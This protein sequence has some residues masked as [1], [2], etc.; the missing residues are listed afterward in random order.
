MTAEHITAAD[1]YRFQFVNDVRIAPDGLRVAFVVR[2]V[3][4]ATE[5]KF[6]NLWMVDAAGDGPPRQF[7]Y[8]DHHDGSPTWSP[9]GRWLAFSS[10]RLDAERPAQLFVI[11]TDGGEAHRLVEIPGEIQEIAWSP[12]GARLALVVRKFDPETLERQK[13]EQKKK[14]GVKVRHYERV[15]YKLDGYGY[16]P[17]ERSHIW[18][19]D[20]AAAQA[21]Q[22]TD[23]SVFDETQVAWSPDGLTLAFVSNRM[24][25]PDARPDADKVWL[26][27]AAG[28]EPRQVEGDAWSCHLPAFSP[29]GRRLAFYAQAAENESFRNVQVWLADVDGSTPARSLTA[30]YDLHASSGVIN[31]TNSQDMLPPTW[32][33][34]GRRLLFPV[35]LHG[36]TK[37]VSVSV[38]GD[39]LRTEMDGERSLGAVT[40]DRRQRRAAF[41]QADF[42]DPGQVMAQDWLDGHPNGQARRLT[43]FNRDWLDQIDLGQVETHWIKGPDGNDLQGWII[44]P[45]GFDPAQKY[46][47][48]LEIHGGPLTQYGYAFMHEFYY[49]AAQGYVVT[50]SNPRGGRGYG[51]SHAGAI[52]GAWGTKDYDDLMA[53]TDFVAAQPYIDPERMGVC[54]G[55]YGGYMTVWMLGHTTR[56]KAAVPM[57]CVSNF[58]SMWGTSDFNWAFQY[59]VHAGAPFEDLE[60]HWQRSPIA[61]I[62]AAV[63]PTL[64]IHSEN[65]HRCPIE[66]SEQVFVALKRLGVPTE[67]VR[68]PDEFH[69]LSR[70][71]RTDRR[72]ARLEHVS[73]WF[74]RYLKAE[75][76]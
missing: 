73:R 50:F 19:V 4:Q 24:P 38:D 49:L 39:D 61:Y 17:H 11:P 65:D 37:M 68:F 5:K 21:Q 9:D 63:T 10:N 66:Q 41:M 53:W 1:L 44:K 76:A 20:V 30:A 32:M 25:D 71:G 56:F 28:G 52:D 14:L 54:G 58:V 7:T 40:F 3:D 34:D 33:L 23:H 43:Q 62:G 13:D 47:S 57:R 46:P 67:F 29:D 27:P 69:G 35:N 36:S 64:V 55:S 18:M 12:D 6:S 59:T 22:L 51:E 75:A 74:N 2:R 8:G 45:P 60:K 15:F 16:L 70:V 42:G 48:I 31:D 72:V 26:M